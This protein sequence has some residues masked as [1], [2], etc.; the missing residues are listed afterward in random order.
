VRKVRMAMLG[1]IA[2]DYN[3]IY[4]LNDNINKRNKENERLF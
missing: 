4:E 2:S 3:L 1:A